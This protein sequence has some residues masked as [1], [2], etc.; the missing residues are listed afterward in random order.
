LGI[1]WL[2]KSGQGI[3]VL[4]VWELLV[5][6]IFNLALMGICVRIYRELRISFRFPSSKVLGDFWEYSSYV[7]LI[8]VFGQ[9]IYYTD[10]L[11]VSAF[12]SV[13]AVT[14]YAI[15]GSLSEYLRQIVA[16]LTT[17]FMPLASRFSASSEHDDLRRLL[18]Q[19]TRITLLVALPILMTLLIR[20][21]TFIGLW[22]GQQYVPISGRVLQILLVAQVFVIA[23]STSINI[24]FGLSKHRPFAFWSGAEAIANL[25]LSILLVKRIGLYGVAVG[26]VIPNLVVHLILLPRYVCNI[27]GVRLRQYIW[28][29]WVRP[30][31]AVIPFAI[32]C[33]LSD[34][35]W[36]ATT[37]PSLFFQIGAILPLYVLSVVFCFWK[38]I[39]LQMK[40]NAKYYTRQH[41]STPIFLT[42]FQNSDSHSQQPNS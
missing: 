20:V 30:G 25:A 12:I 40:N 16:S 39:V 32:A 19:G 9:V 28:Q 22:M 7:F 14:F 21:H 4:A 35:Y 13:T 42:T 36:K 10:N 2:L 23:N 1:V 38:E 34:R 33:Y 15:G 41:A 29:C 37:L 3:V 31:L 18:I 17:T 26:T 6:I 8:H 24:A 27:V 5:T 11:M